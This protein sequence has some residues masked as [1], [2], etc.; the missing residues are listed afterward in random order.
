MGGCFKDIPQNEYFHCCRCAFLAQVLS[1]TFYVFDEQI[2]V[3][4][5]LPLAGTWI[6]F[7]LFNAEKVYLRL[8]IFD[9]KNTLFNYIFRLDF[10]N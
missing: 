5:I 6:G 7:F 10:L 2:P 8:Q 9:F 3:S 1:L 4:P